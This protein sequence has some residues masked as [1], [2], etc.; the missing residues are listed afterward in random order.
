MKAY[1][2][3]TTALSLLLSTVSAFPQTK[4]AADTA[5]D[6]AY[7]AIPNFFK[8]P[9]GESLGEVQGVA[10]NSKGHIFAYFRGPQTRLWEFDQN[11]NFVKEIGKDFYGFRFAHS[12]RVDH[13]DNIWTVD[14]GTN[15]VTKF[16]PTGTKVLMVIGHRPSHTLGPVAS[17]KPVPDGK[18][19]LCRP[20]DVAWDLQGNIFIA[21]GYCN[22]R[23]IKYDKNGRF[24]AES[25]SYLAG[26]GESEYNL[27][28][29]IQVDH[30]GNVYVADR[31]NNRYVVLDNNLKWKTAYTQFGTAWSS[32][33]SEG[34]RQYLFLT[35]SNPNGNPP[36]SWARTGQIYKAELD[37]TVIGKFGKAGK[38][39]PNFQ[40]VHSIDCRNPDELIVG[41][42]ESWRMQ[43]FVLRG[44]KGS[45]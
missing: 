23:V 1:L 10:T 36:G 42:I 33:I 22:H 43:K 38:M 27:P 29:G 5:P 2:A 40:V 24:V 30:Q 28:H 37:G 15:V 34:P 21:D 44:S 18:Y 41:E 20:S 13:D 7:E 45:K 39:A 11:G 35:N 9:A 31:T 6:L 3:V 14:E 16:D 12:V 4:A 8:V 17:P 26:K 32:C 19:T 25:G